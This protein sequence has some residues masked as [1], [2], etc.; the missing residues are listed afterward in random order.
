ML[1]RSH[2]DATFFGSDWPSYLT[3]K[4]I[5][6]E[7]LWAKDSRHQT[8]M[9]ARLFPLAEDVTDWRN[10]LWLQ[11]FSNNTL[12]LSRLES[13]RGSK[14]YSMVTAAYYFKNLFYFL[15][16]YFYIQE[17]FLGMV[18]PQNAFSNLRSTAAAALMQAIRQWPWSLLPYFHR[19]YFGEP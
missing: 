11:D 6:E 10:L 7:D 1:E 13:W 2:P 12:A 9:N 15:K 19:S 4:G 14:R 18:D 17:D 8:L 3:V 16:F 5:K